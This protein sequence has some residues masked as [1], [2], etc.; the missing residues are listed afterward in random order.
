M[1]AKRLEKPSLIHLKDICYKIYATKSISADD[2][3]TD[4]PVHQE[5]W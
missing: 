2:L 4:K 1:P 5:S 3:E